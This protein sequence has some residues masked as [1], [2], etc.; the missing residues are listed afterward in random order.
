MS[1]KASQINMAILF[2]KG[3][4]YI[5]EK[6]KNGEDKIAA[7]SFLMSLLEKQKTLLGFIVETIFLL[8]ESSDS[9]DMLVANM[10]KSAIDS[11]VYQLNQL[12]VHFSKDVKTL[13]KEAMVSTG[14]QD[15]KGNVVDSPNY[16]KIPEH[17]LKHV[18]SSVNVLQD[19]L[20]SLETPDPITPVNLAAIKELRIKL[21][22]S[23]YNLDVKASSETEAASQKPLPIVKVISENQGTEDVED[24][25]SV[26][27]RTPEEIVEECRQEQYGD[28]K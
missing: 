2:T 15:E 19:S 8:T 6:T 11:V 24:E 10:T 27:P 22:G 25:L 7:L 14:L 26:K 20:L 23:D 13:Q 21:L 28:K 12:K 1:K 9:E 3:P 5:A 17:F 16:A 4:E 18:I